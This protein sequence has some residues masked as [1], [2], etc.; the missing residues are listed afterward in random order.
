MREFWRRFWE[1]CSS[2]KWTENIS[3]WHLEWPKRNYS[4]FDLFFSMLHLISSHNVLQSA[5][6]LSQPHL[7]NLQHR[8]TIFGYFHVS[9]HLD[10]ESRT[11][12]NFKML[13]NF[14]SRSRNPLDQLSTNDA[15]LLSAI[16]VDALFVI[17]LPSLKVECEKNQFLDRTRCKRNNILVTYGWVFCSTVECAMETF[18]MLN[19]I[20]FSRGQPHP[21]QKLH[22][23]ISIK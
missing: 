6:T 12:F 7:E 19:E 15:Y 3:N 13:Q 4:E 22:W 8:S 20:S 21:L 16:V 5:Y 9:F 2:R 14:P 1:F 18:L 23:I 10:W 17:D 11:Q